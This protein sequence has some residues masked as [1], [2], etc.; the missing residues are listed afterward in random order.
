MSN[1]CFRCGD[2]TTITKAIVENPNNSIH[3]NTLTGNTKVYQKTIS[4]KSVVGFER[5]DFG[6][7]NNTIHYV[8]SSLIPNYAPSLDSATVSASERNGRNIHAFISNGPSG[9]SHFHPGASIGGSAFTNF[10]PDGK[11]Y[12]FGTNISSGKIHFLAGA[13]RL[14][15]RIKENGIDMPGFNNLTLGDENV[16]GSWRFAIDSDNLVIQKKISGS[17]VTKHTIPT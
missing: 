8:A 9:F 16:D 15:M 13:N 11:I 10:D 12:S 3:G 2:N 4:D 6:S 1:H 17:W 5:R 7:I 14:K